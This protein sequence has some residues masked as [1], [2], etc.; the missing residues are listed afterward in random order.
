MMK[1]QKGITLVALIITIIVML[2]LVAVTISIA[3]NGGLFDKARTASKETRI[4]QAREAVAL[5]KADVISDYYDPT[6][7]LVGGQ[8]KDGHATSYL[9]AKPGAN[10]IADLINAY[11]DEDK[12]EVEVT[13]ENPYTVTIVND[14]INT[15]ISDSDFTEELVFDMWT[16]ST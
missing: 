1:G 3:L 9:G 7:G 13:G 16:A 4:A 2:I 12:I 5:A 15:D 6:N 10:K 8:V 11:L 14:T